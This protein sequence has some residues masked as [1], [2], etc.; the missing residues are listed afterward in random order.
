[1]GSRHAVQAISLFA[2]HFPAKRW[3]EG[4]LVLHGRHDTPVGVESLSKYPEAQ[5]HCPIDVAP[6]AVVLE[7]GGQ[8]SQV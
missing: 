6:A 2:V 3:P 1:M 4:Q 5:T 7:N 8:G